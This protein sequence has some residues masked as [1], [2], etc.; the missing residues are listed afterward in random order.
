[1]NAH[2]VI[3]DSLRIAD[4]VWKPYVADLSDEELLVRPVDG[5]N[6][7]A[8]QLGHLISSERE[9]VEQIC[10]GSMPALPEGFGQAYTSET[11]QRD[12]AASFHKKDEYLSLFETVRAATLEALGR[13]SAE[14]LDQQAPEHLQQIAP[15]FGAVFDL[16]GAHWLMHAGQWAVIRRKLGRPPLF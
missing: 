16:I 7:I 13:L 11:S 1:M 15:T 12:D 14:Q 3:R 5:A 9:M 10:P 4:A 6:H 2:D 8:W